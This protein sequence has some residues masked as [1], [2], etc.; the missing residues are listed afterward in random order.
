MDRGTTSLVALSEARPAKGLRRV[1]IAL[2]AAVLLVLLVAPSVVGATYRIRATDNDTW[3]PAHRFI[4]KGDRIVW[5]NPT[6]ARHDIFKYRGKWRR[7]YLDRNFQPGETVGKR[8]RKRGNYYYRCR[9]HSAVF[10]G[11]CQ[12]M[13]GRIHVVAP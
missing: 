12:G 6:N 5:K 7:G 4:E 1:S 11:S 9:I 13:C 8:L 3:R 10:D 2:V